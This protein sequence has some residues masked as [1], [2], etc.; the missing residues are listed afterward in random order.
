MAR[1]LQSKNIE[2]MKKYKII[3][4]PGREKA[5]SLWKRYPTPMIIF[6]G[7][8]GAII[9]IGSLGMVPLMLYMQGEDLS[10]IGWEWIGEFQSMD[11]AIAAKIN[12]EQPPEKEKVWYL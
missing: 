6:L 10:N 8:L 1:S 11:D 3:E 7:V 2:T 9:G 4:S 5:Y 12:D